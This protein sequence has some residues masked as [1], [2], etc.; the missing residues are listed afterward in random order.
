MTSELKAD[1]ILITRES[2]IDLLNNKSITDII[3]K[4]CERYIT[5]VATVSVY[6]SDGMLIKKVIDEDLYQEI[7]LNLI[8]SLPNLKKKLE[9]HFNKNDELQI[10]FS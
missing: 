3:L 6:D 2:I 7:S 1:K 10:K 4:K 5:E 8:Q 9:R